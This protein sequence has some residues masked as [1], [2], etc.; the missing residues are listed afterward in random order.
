MKRCPELRALSGDHH[1]AL[2][3][4]R[5]LARAADHEGGLSEDA[6]WAELEA[7]FAAELEP[8]FQIEESLLAPAL[9]AGPD[10]ALVVRLREDHEVLRRLV[11]PGGAR[12]SAELRCFAE[13]L[14]RHVRFEEHELFEA[15]QRTM[16]PSA[17]QAVAL[18]CGARPRQG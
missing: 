9:E 5:T 1:H 8:H 17:L 3:L 15:A 2:V 16:T 11:A 14:E 13:T 12:T 6:A 7:R 4:A 10:S 18:A